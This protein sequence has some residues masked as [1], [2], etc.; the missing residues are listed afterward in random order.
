MSSTD[1]TRFDEL[2]SQIVQFVQPVSTMTVIDTATSAIAAGAL[3][4][5]KEFSKE[6][7]ARR[8]EAV[9]P[10]NEQ[11]KSINNY[12]REIAAPLVAAELE[13]KAKMG[14]WANAERVRLENERKEAEE[15]RKQEQRRLDEER[16]AREAEVRAKA[17]SER[18]ELEAKIAA[19]TKVRQEKESKEREALA[20]FAVDPKEAE[21]RAEAERS[22]FAER[23]ER[24]R[25]EA[26]TR[27]AI[28]LRLNEEQAQRIK[29]EM[30][31]A[32]KQALK[33]AEAARPK[34]L[35]R[36]V[37]FEITEPALVPRE[38]LTVDQSLV[39]SA[40]QAAAK[41]NPGYTIP[42]VTWMIEF[43]VT[44]R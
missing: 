22:E 30:E 31:S 26:E 9:S 40:L 36:V 24:Q 18:K 6:I 8:V 1:L 21:K 44:A 4:T 13:I 35:R 43:E 23:A 38:F 29:A 17:E 41:D 42:G 32:A 39:R 16:R 10:L 25:K 3:R 15:Q 12:A 27:E 37:K 33:A 7:E 11:V 20:M 5:V 28:Q 14:E 2:R 19:E 34:N